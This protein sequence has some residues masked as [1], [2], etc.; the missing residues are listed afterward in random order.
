MYVLIIQFYVLFS[1]TT[2]GN[3]AENKYMKNEKLLTVMENEN[4]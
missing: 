2:F 1:L 4:R 3:R